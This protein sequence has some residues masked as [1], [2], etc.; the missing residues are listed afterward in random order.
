[1]KVWPATVI[2]PVRCGPVFA[3]TE[4][5]TAPLP[6]PLAP[7]EMVIHAAL[8]VAAHAQPVVVVTLMLPVPPEA[9]KLWLVGL[10]ENVQPGS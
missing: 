2:V 6:L 8:L 1:M 4:N 7:L 10:I 9:A 3:A 5:W